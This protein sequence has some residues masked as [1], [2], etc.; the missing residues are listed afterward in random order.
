M[1]IFS[2][3]VYYVYW[4]T[5]RKHRSVGGIQSASGHACLLFSLIAA[6]DTELHEG[7]KTLMSPVFYFVFLKRI[8]FKY[9]L[10]TFL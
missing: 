10:N 1:L 7:L 5:F 6:T 2:L 8:A 9:E 3:T 4:Y